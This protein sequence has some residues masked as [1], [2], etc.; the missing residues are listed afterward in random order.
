MPEPATSSAWG[1]SGNRLGSED[2]PE[3]EAA[4]VVPHFDAPENDAEGDEDDES[5]QIRRLTFWRNGFSI[6][7]GPLLSYEDPENKQ[8]LE[9]IQAGRAPRSVFDVAFNQP[10]QVEVAK[11]LNE[12]YQPPPKQPMKAFEG[13]GNR[14]GSAAPAVVSGTS[15]PTMPGSFASGAASSSA[16]PAPASAPSFSVDNNKPTTSIQVRLADGTR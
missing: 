5:P 11:R 4:P 6:Q 16:P 12:D 9:A 13:S 2:D 3:P 15:T 7:D 10:L 1:S 14:L 8:L